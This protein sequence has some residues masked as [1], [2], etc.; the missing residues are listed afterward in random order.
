MFRL[1]AGVT[2]AFGMARKRAKPN[3]SLAERVAWPLNGMLG[4]WGGSRGRESRSFTQF[5][6][7]AGMLGEVRPVKSEARIRA[8]EASGLADMCSM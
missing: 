2:E 1:G 6:S 4:S 5:T 3:L 7:A 8:T